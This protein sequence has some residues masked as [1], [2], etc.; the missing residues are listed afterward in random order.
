MDN[1]RKYQRPPF[2]EI[3]ESWKALLAE[4]GLPTECLWI[5]DENLCFEKA[6]SN[7]NG[8]QVG[9]QTAFSPPPPDAERVA[10][11]YFADFD[12]RLVFYRLGT[13]RGKS[14]CL[15]LCD[16][17]FETRTDANGYIRKDAWH[18]AFRPGE[19]EELEEITSS[20]RFKHR[21]LRNRPLHDLD[22]CMTLRSVHELMAHGRVLSAYERYALR[23]FH[24]WWKLLGHRQK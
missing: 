1:D 20:E 12:A 13:C 17:W 3:F 7:P 16:E 14:V 21:L 11:D 22:F 6:A 8:F 4:R 24:G 5:F 15:L 23:F 19:K 18:A 10:Y 2:Q 9:F